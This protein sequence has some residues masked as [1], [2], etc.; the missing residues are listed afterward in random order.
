M[1]VKLYIGVEVFGLIVTDVHVFLTEDEQ[2]DW[3]KGYVGLHH[4][5]RHLIKP[6]MSRDMIHDIME[7]HY[8]EMGEDYQETKLFDVEIDIPEKGVNSGGSVEEENPGSL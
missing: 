6:D 7:Q 2:Y 4:P 8:S 3:Y 1:K 5:S